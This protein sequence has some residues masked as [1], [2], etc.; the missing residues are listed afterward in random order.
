MPAKI[1]G[2]VAHLEGSA[3]VRTPDGVVKL[4]SVGDQVH[5]GDLLVTGS[6]TDVRISFLSGKQ[7]EVGADSEV[8]LD[9]TVYRPT[10]FTE[11]EVVADVFAL[12]QKILDGE[13]DL[14]E[15]ES[16]LD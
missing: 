8:L 13:L 16:S 15:L 6:A 2:N 1:I 12:Q 10:T 9:E 5:E 7:L 4:L 14:A 11:S 3:E